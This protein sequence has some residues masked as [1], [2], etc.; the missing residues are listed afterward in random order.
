MSSALLWFSRKSPSAVFAM[1][2]AMILLGWILDSAG[3]SPIFRSVG[4]VISTTIFFGY[5]FLLIFGFPA[6][7]SSRAARRLSILS[8]SVLGLIYIASLMYDPSA[9]E[10]QITGSWIKFIIGVPIDVLVFAPFF[11]PSHI[12]GQA[13]R[14][15]GVYKPLDSIGAWVSL[16]FCAFGGVFFLHRNVAS[17][18]QSLA[19]LGQV[20]T[21]IGHRDTV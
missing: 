3:P 16:F 20:S 19:D 15:L 4:A 13:R 21:P 7:Y 8:L 17:A 18:V 10:N 2:W 11:V 12:L 9:P 1:I 14:S 5:P 6:Q